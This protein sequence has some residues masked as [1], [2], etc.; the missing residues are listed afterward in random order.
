[1]THDQPL[2]RARHY[3]RK[4]FINFL[5][6]ERN[7]SPRTVEEYEKDLKVFFDYFIPLLESGLTLGAIDERTVREFLTHLKI[8]KRYTANAVNRKIACLKSYFKF[9]EKEKHIERSPMTDIKSLR[10]P[11]HLPKVL[12]EQEVGAL[13]QK[14]SEHT[15]AKRNRDFTFRRDKAIL[16]LFYATGM[17]ISELTGLDVDDIDLEN[18]LARVTGKG[19]KQRMVILN[20]TASE[21]LRDYL[22]VRRQRGV[23]ALFLNRLNGRI[24][25][26]AVEYMFAKTMEKCEIS[27]KASPHTL[28]HSFATHMLDGGADLMTIK[29][30]LGHESLSTTQIYTNI[31]MQ[32]IKEVYEQSHPRE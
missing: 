31:S 24:S 23:H 11:K 14:A 1:M 16:E 9:L 26:R 2:E 15:D 8:E 21:A 25:N 12:S 17:R 22:E 7:L 28:R 10:M 19:N 20:V 27:R 5:V 6:V 32:R 3:F 29:E 30:L 4:D 13:L 18:R